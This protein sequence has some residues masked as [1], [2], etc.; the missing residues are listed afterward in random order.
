M[1]Y[2]L[3]LPELM[4]AGAPEGY[5]IFS[6][7]GAPFFR[8]FSN[9]LYSDSNGC[10]F[11]PRLISSVSI[12]VINVMG[13]HWLPLLSSQHLFASLEVSDF[14]P[15]DVMIWGSAK[16]FTLE[17]ESPCWKWLGAAVLDQAIRRFS[18]EGKIY[19]LLSK[20][21]SRALSLTIP[22]R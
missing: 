22:H 7:G 6:S 11:R 20:E 14:N 13:I 8:H 21:P 4:V 16:F 18:C 2:K 19:F 9:M 15:W 5:G 12:F 3:V 10:S 17:K 1:C